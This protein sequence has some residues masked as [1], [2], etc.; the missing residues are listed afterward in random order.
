M[1]HLEQRQALNLP[2]Q[3]SFNPE[4]GLTIKGR[5]TAKALHYAA[6]MPGAVLE[7][8][9]LAVN[10]D[11]TFEYFFNPALFNNKTNTYDTINLVSGKPEIMDVVHLTFFSEEAAVQGKAYH[12][13]AR[14][15]FRG[16]KVF[17][18]Q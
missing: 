16:N 4:M 6:I 15:I 17:Y 14:V 13:F 8:G 12:S 1:R 3:S 10:A 9:E 18:A 2:E 11:G 7:Q 5:S